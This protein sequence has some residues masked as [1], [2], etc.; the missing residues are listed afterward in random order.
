MENNNKHETDGNV[1]ESGDLLA[2]KDITELSWKIVL[3]PHAWIG[4]REKMQKYA[5]ELG[6][7]YFMWNDIIYETKTMRK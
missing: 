7:P 2:G 1:F 6:Y 4:H 5:V 3:Y